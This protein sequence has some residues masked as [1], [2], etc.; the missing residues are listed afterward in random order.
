MMLIAQSCEY[1]KNLIVHFKKGLILCYELYLSLKN[2]RELLNGE[3]VGNFPFMLFLYCLH[4][5][6]SKFYLYIQKK[7]EW[8]V[9]IGRAQK[10]QFCR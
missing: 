9:L 7:K 8:N 2:S 1:I 5:F 3:I 6:V 10:Y 4:F